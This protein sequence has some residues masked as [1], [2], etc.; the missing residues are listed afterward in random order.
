[1][2]IEALALCHNVTP[3]KPDDSEKYEYEA[4]S[5][6]EQALVEISQE[7]GVELVQRDDSIVK[8]K[9]PGGEK[10]YEILECFKFTSK[11]KRMGILLK[12]L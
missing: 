7:V 9:V 4:Q 5:P 8:I 1:M 11:R 12:D 10:K 2:L 3:T 6:D